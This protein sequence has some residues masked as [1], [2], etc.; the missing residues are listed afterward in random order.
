MSQKMKRARI[1]VISGQFAWLGSS[2]GMLRLAQRIRA[3][4]PGSLTTTH[5]WKSPDEIAMDIMARG[6]DVP[7][8]IIGY[9]LGANDVPFIASRMQRTE[10]A[11]GVCYDP[12][13]YGIMVKPTPQN[14]KRLLLYHNTGTVGFG[15]ALFEGPNVERTDVDTN[16][17]AICYNES[18][19]QKTMYAVWK[20]HNE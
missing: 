12:S 17:L 19:H 14:I 13:Q 16:H 10:I 1:Y 18:L 7:K 8:I 5:G 9:S 4:F 20:V 3:S 2:L 11:L 6:R 15:H